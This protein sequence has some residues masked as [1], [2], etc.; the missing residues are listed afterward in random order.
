MRG[1]A[2]IGN[3]DNEARF[4]QHTLI[5]FA[6]G[7]MLLL[8]VQLASGAPE[9]SD[10]IRRKDKL[11]LTGFQP[12]HKAWL[13][14]PLRRYMADV[15]DV[16]LEPRLDVHSNVVP[17]CYTIDTVAKVKMKGGREKQ[18]SI[19]RFKRYDPSRLADML[20]HLG[21]E[22]LTQSPFG[23]DPNAPVQTLML[24]RRISPSFIE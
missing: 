11:L 6:P 10:E 14:G 9:R 5:G 3:L 23:P 13:A 19:F 18:F 8:D 7:D 21:W 2:T 1:N 15:V 22:L 17:G 4:F 24:F 20:R 16:D 12:G